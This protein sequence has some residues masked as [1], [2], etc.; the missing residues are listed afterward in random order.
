MREHLRPAVA[1][2]PSRLL[3]VQCAYH[4][5]ATHTPCI[6]NACGSNSSTA[7]LAWPCGTA[8]CACDVRTMRVPG[9][10]CYA[11]KKHVPAW[12]RVTA[13]G[14]LSPSGACTL[15]GTAALAHRVAPPPVRRA[16]AALSS[17]LSSQRS[18]GGAK[19]VAGG[20]SGRERPEIASQFSPP[21]RAPA[22]TSDPPPPQQPH[23]PPPSSTG[24]PCACCC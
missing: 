10:C 19:R 20:A 9:I 11:Q 6:R 3:H 2:A 1:A 13:E 7:A 18:S 4:A 21:P 23:A 22:A 12:P 24:R 17:P 5:Y 15:R 8:H 16:R 14:A